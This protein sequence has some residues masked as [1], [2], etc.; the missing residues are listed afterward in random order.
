VGK[1]TGLIVR[2]GQYPNLHTRRVHV[3][4]TDKGGAKGVESSVR[5]VAVTDLEVCFP[6][7]L[8]VVA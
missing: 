2:G 6:N 3:F 5:G 1:I 4:F 7:L 8:G